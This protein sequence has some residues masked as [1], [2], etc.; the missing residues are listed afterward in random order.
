MCVLSGEKS[1]IISGNNAQEIHL[2]NIQKLSQMNPEELSLE[3]QKLISELNPNILN[4]L[5]NR[6]KIISVCDKNEDSMDVSNDAEYIHF[7]LAI[8]VLSE[9]FFKT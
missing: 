3:R 5:Q 1:F 8:G 7:L 6:R 2:E 9:S 4:F